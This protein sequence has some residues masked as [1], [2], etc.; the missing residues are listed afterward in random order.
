VTVPRSVGDW[1]HGSPAWWVCF[2]RLLWGLCL[3][4]ASVSKIFVIYKLVNRLVCGLVSFEAPAITYPTNSAEYCLQPIHPDDP[5][6]W[7][8]A[9]VASPRIGKSSGTLAPVTPAARSRS[10][11]WMLPASGKPFS[12]LLYLQGNRQSRIKQTP[13]ASLVYT[14]RKNEEKRRWS[15]AVHC[16]ATMGIYHKGP[17]L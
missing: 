15:K 3:K 14:R 13:R 7:T 17:M 16:L 5:D 1:G 11:R 8:A 12:T 10:C 2:L 4:V 6:S 9:T